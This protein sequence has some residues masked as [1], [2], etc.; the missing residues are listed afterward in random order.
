MSTLAI[1]MPSSKLTLYQLTI[2][3]TYTILNSVYQTDPNQ[4]HFETTPSACWCYPVPVRCPLTGR[5]LHVFVVLSGLEVR[6]RCTAGRGER[7]HLEQDPRRRMTRIHRTA[8]YI[9][10]RKPI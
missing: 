4:D 1:S 7:H 3:Q 8:A 2:Q 5:V 6:D 10:C 9:H